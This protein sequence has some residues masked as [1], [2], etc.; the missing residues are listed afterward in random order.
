[1]LQR[2]ILSLDGP[3]VTASGFKDELAVVTHASDCLSSGDQVI[4]FTHNG[5]IVLVG[6]L[7]ITVV[8]QLWWYRLCI[9]VF[10]TYLV[11]Q[12]PSK[13]VYH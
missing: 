10:S 4:T 2:Y 13:D 1:M 9:C 11:V 12:S 6:L 8:Y 7:V 5:F 3:V